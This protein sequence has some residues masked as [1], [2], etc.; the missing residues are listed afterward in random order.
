M[1]LNA[2]FWGA[3][4]ATG[5]TGWDLG[6]VSPP[7]Q[8]WFSGFTDKAM[9]I[10]IPGG[11]RSWEAEH[12]HR[13]GFRHVHVVDLTDA[14]WR[15]LTAR[16][17]DFPREHFH[18]GDFFAHAGR[19]HRI[20][21]QTFFCALDPGL[22][23]AYVEKMHGLLVPGGI[24]GGVLFND[25]LNADRPPFGGS[26]EEYR[27]LFGTLFTDLRLDPCHNSVAPRAGRELWLHARR[28]PL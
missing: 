6:A 7:L 21:E 13:Q 9:R 5:D 16:C 28:S 3:R 1:E 14:P 27:T 23:K 10:L 26:L 20:V 17:P 19:Y 25:A 8:A 22:R 2:G 12:L 18:I 4:Y 15:E 11:G 24:L